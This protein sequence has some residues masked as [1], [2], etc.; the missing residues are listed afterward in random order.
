MARPRI[1]EDVAHRQALRLTFRFQ[2][3]NVELILMEPIAMIVPPSMDISD[4]PPGAAFWYELQDGKQA[5]IDRRVQRD[6]LDPS[7][8]VQ[9]GAGGDPAT[10]RLT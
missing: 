5:T 9:T 7:V 2:R 10:K 3:S 4:Q 1:E 6:P 8:E